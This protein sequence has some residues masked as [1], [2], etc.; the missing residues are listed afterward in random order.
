MFF[1]DNF[2]APSSKVDAADLNGDGTI[3]LVFANGKGFDKGDA[4]SVQLQQAFINDGGMMTDV[5]DVVFG[6]VP[7]AG[8]AVKLRDI[9]YDGDNDIILGTTWSTQSQLFINTDGGGNF[10]NETDTNLPQ[11]PASIGDLEV[12]DV[13]DDGDLDIA[14]ANWGNPGPGQSVAQSEGGITLL[15]TQMGDPANFGD[16]G[17]AMFEDVTLNQMPGT[18]IRWSWETEFID[19][20][21]DYDLD[22]VV[23]ANVGDQFSLFL[24]TNDGTGTF[25]D[26]TN[27]NIPQ[28]RFSQDVE[29]MDVD[30][31][32]DTDLLTLHDGPTGRDR[33]LLNENGKFTDSTDVLWPKLENPPSFD[34]TAVFY[35]HNSD[36]K[37]DFVTGAI[38]TAQDKYTDRLV[39]N[40]AGKFKVNK[41]A[42]QEL[43]PS[44]G[45]YAITLADFNKDTRLDLAMA[46]NENAF[47][48]KVFLAS[49][50]LPADTVAPFFSNVEEL[51]PLM[52][53]GNKV[54]HLRCH[55]NKS[56]LMLHDFLQTDSNKGFPYIESWT[57]G[58]PFDPDNEPGNLTSPGQWY[59]E[60][61]WRINFEVPDADSV[62]YRICA[63]DAAGNKRCTP[64]SPEINISP[65]GT[66]TDTDA[67]DSNTDGGSGENTGTVSDTPGTLS[68]SNSNTSPSESNSDTVVTAGPPTESNSVSD[69]D[70][71]GAPTESYSAS[72]SA[73]ESA[74]SEGS[75]DTAAESGLYE[76]DLGGCVCDGSGAGS[77]GGTAGLLVLLALGGRR[78]R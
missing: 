25:T 30:A 6:G 56:P 4:T 47:E 32:G 15:W 61:L 58:A 64:V 78:R 45:T 8:R 28:G 29:P 2:N 40:Q 59:G 37:V 70:S 54:V 31:D 51:G 65:V 17:T 13:D 76:V 43:L 21:N 7:Y 1:D 77:T 57:E 34:V 35:D 24:F 11:G 52:F 72:Q 27:S 26:T 42:F 19:A 10:S 16:A 50:E 23:N 9:D 49:D 22:I 75:A 46:Q 67:T 68:E 53:P 38:Q 60:Y 48:K 33:L 69:A 74:Q 20:D 44:S 63:I 12:G 66:S 55:D 62:W 41:T 5:S 14:L 18:K 39:F 3:D 73:S 36:G 71:Q